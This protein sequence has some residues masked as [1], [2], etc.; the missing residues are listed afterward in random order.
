MEVSFPELG[1][2][3]NDCIEASWIRSVLYNAEFSTSAS[4]DVLLNRTNPNKSYFK[5]KL[6]YVEETCIGERVGRVVEHL[7]EGLWNI[8][9]QEQSGCMIWTP[10]G[11]RMSEISEFEIPFPHRTGNMY[12]IQY[13][14]TW[15]EEGETKEHLQ[16]IKKLYGYMTPFVS[17]NPRSSYLNYRDLDFGD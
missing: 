8:L 14:V 4:Y 6:D 1:V 11:G 16:W 15:E 12:E 9:L 7:L 5:G 3:R 13:M 17:K 10:Y 2:S